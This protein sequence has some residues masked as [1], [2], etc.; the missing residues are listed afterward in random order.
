MI[1]GYRSGI[2]YGVRTKNT[3]GG[4]KGEKK[5]SAPKNGIWAAKSE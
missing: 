2:L 1:P 4:Q 3:F 5:P